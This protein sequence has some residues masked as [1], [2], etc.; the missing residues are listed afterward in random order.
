MASAATGD[1]LLALQTVLSKL[2]LD[3]LGVVSVVSCSGGGGCRFQQLLVLINE[4]EVAHKLGH[5]SQTG[6]VLMHRDNRQ[7]SH[8][9]PYLVLRLLL[10]QLARGSVGFSSCLSDSIT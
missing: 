10:L 5:A 3:T 8:V 4:A 6:S 1:V 2:S 7:K 9:S